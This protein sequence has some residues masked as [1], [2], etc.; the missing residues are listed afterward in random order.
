[1]PVFVASPQ[2]TRTRALTP[3]R[4]PDRPLRRVTT[5]SPER[6]LELPRIPAAAFETFTRN[7]EI[8][9]DAGVPLV[10]ALQVQGEHAESPGIA[11]LSRGLLQQLNAGISLGEAVDLYPRTFSSVY[12]SLIRAGEHSGRL[13]LMLRELAD[14]LAWR[15]EV[16]KTVR[17]AA[18]Y[19]VLVLV[20]T[21]GLLLLIVGYVLPKFD[22]L[23]TRLG[24]DV[25]TAAVLLMAT[26]NF[27]SQH[28]V[29][30]VASAAALPLVLLAL[31]RQPGARR[32]IYR[33]AARL[34]L[35][36]R[37]L[38]AIDLARLTR[39]LAILSQAGIP[40]I[41]ALELSRDAVADAGLARKLSELCAAV[42]GGQ[43]LS[44]AAAG[45]AVFPPIALNLITIGEESGQMATVLDRLARGFDRSA[46]E[47]VQKAL[48]MLEPAFTLV[49]G[50]LVGGLAIVVISTLYKTMMAVGR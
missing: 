33:C 29:A 16:R 27:V 1:M 7:L 44:Q 40:L 35:V 11:A 48:A 5:A 38:R 24:D 4:R 39:T 12:R 22:A 8:Q 6:G 50:V 42:V 14:F 20:A 28:M 49:L 46:R 23:F 3:P 9:L 13:P 21:F 47:A 45:S 25:P 17:R 18:T 2:T 30:I 19:P 31:G 10:R 43:T 36:G 34:P 26:G 32:H 37:V 15:E 41:G